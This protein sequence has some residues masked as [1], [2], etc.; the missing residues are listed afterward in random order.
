MS[1][2]RST[3]WKK[4]SFS[5][6]LTACVEVR[7]VDGQVAVRSSRAPEQEQTHTKPE[8][9]AFIAGV[10]AGEFDYLLD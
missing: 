9:A 10:K 4:S 7:V 3:E 1:G 8:M 5:A 6:G 2:A